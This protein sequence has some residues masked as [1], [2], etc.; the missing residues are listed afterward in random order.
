MVQNIIWVPKRNISYFN[1]YH[2]KYKDFYTIQGVII[3]VYYIDCEKKKYQCSFKV[4]NK[5]DVE[6]WIKSKSHPIDW[7]LF[8]TFSF[9]L[10]GDKVIGNA[11]ISKKVRRKICIKRKSVKISKKSRKNR[12]PVKEQGVCGYNIRKITYTVKQK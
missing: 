1:N 3:K 7:E 12:E 10:S 5:D 6:I 2:L 11:N 8:D 4:L 9:A